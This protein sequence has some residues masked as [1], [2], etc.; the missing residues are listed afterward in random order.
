MLRAVYALRPPR[1]CAGLGALKTARAGPRVN[2]SPLLHDAVLFSTERPRPLRSTPLAASA[3]ALS[4]GRRPAARAALASAV[5]KASRLETTYPWSPAVGILLP[6]SRFYAATAP[7]EPDV[8]STDPYRV[9][10]IERTA[11]DK[12]LKRAYLHAAKRFHP[13]MNPGS[14]QAKKHFQRVSQ[15]YDLLRDPARRAAYDA[16]GQWEGTGPAS[17]GGTTWSQSQ[18]EQTFNQAAADR[19]V[20]LEAVWMYAEAV[21]EEALLAGSLAREGKWSEVWPLVRE[22]RG[23]L[24]ALGMLVL[25]IRFPAAVTLALRGALVFLVNMRLA[26]GVRRQVWQYAWRSLVAAAHRQRARLRQRARDR[27]QQQK[28]GSGARMSSGKQ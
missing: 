13:D 19:E 2:D 9:L 11:T 16:S 10:G 24:A 1:R 17:D 6:R 7:P 20:I 22:H 4:Q 27:K 8:A 12:E 25:V 14:D 18:A 3:C 21:K 26:P 5:E 15:A 23:L 28:R